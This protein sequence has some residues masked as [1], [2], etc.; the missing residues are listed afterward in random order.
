VI[1]LLLILGI[2]MWMVNSNLGD[3]GADTLTPPDDTDEDDTTTP[4]EHE[5]E[6]TYKLAIQINGWTDNDYSPDPP[7]DMMFEIFD[8]VTYSGVGSGIWYDSLYLP[9]T[10]SA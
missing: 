6:L 2:G 10:G 4:I 7:G 9:Y 1:G 8:L 3:E 5:P